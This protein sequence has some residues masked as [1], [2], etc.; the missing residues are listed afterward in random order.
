MRNELPTILGDHPPDEDPLVDPIGNFQ[1]PSRL[2]ALLSILLIFYCYEPT[3]SEQPTLDVTPTEIHLFP[4]DAQ[5]LLVTGG[6][7]RIRD[8]IEQAVLTSRDPEIARIT[9]Q[10]T[11]RGLKPGHTSIEIRW[12]NQTINVPVTIGADNQRPEIRFSSDIV[13]VLTKL[14]CNSGGCHGKATGQGQFKLSLLGFDPPLDYLALVK[15]A[16]GRR[17]FPGAPDRSLMLLK[18]TAQMPHGGGRRLAVDDDDYRVLKQWIASGSVGPGGPETKLERIEVT[19]QRQTLM[20]ESRQQLL[21]TAHYANGESRDVTRRTLYQSNQPDLARV[22]RTGRVQTTSQRGL[23]SVMARFAGKISTFYAAVPYVNDQQQEQRIEAELSKLEA[24]PEQSRFDRLLIQQWRQLGILPSAVA[25]DTRFIRRA[26]IDICGTMPTRNEIQA[27]VNDKAK[28][29]RARLIDQL[30][31]RPEYASY[32]ALKW[33]DILQNRGSGYS[34]SKQRAGT[35]MFSR[36]I[37]DRIAM[38]TR[39]DRFVTDIITA[40]GSQLENPPTIWHRHV[41]TLPDYVESVAQ[42]FLGVR[43]QCAQCHHHP[44][45]RWSQADYYGLAAV[46]SRV[47]RKGGFADAEVPTNETIFLRD[48][49][50]VF[51][52]RTHEQIAPRALGGPDF[53]LSRYDDPRIHLARWMTRPDNP[54]LARTMTNRLWAHFMGRGIIQPIDDARSTNPPSNPALLEALSQDF[55]AHGYDIKHLIRN[56][57]NSL[58]YR[59]DSA[60]HEFNAH[61]AQTFAR[62]YPRRLTAEVLLDAISQVLEV[63]TVFAGGPGKFP[64]GTRAIELPDENVPVHFLDVFGRPARDS[65]CECERVDSPAL[66][67]ALELINSEL[68]QGKLAAKEGYVARLIAQPETPDRNVEDIFLRVFARTPRSEELATAI[69]FLKDT[70]PEEG[71]RSLVWSLL[72]TNEFM[73]NH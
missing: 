60:P 57:C 72:A 16:R 49:G 38:N 42:A 62:F 5:Q 30:L 24:S 33:A 65:A 19:P 28:D 59:L 68:L 71:Y 34:T 52:P 43:I 11:V 13:P 54:F 56:V 44:F 46:F 20:P 29:K 63:P 2:V 55:I 25:D 12:E 73:F 18:A 7:P 17:L 37:R 48:S 35:S 22:S 14:G 32:F 66:S 4:D 27:Y 3:R 1:L 6:S 70:A 50:K 64:A 69:Q 58:A 61:D 40:S 53:D 47:G 9:G 26:T 51:H 31:E 39:Y 45:E 23:F 21:V 8:V 10:G 36:W 67:Q 41:R 15:E